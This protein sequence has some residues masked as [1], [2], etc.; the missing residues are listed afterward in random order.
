MK[1]G[2]EAS[3]SF[4]SCL[5]VPSHGFGG[6]RDI[7]LKTKESVTRITVAGPHLDDEWEP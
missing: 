6:E 2:S 4:R 7:L 3:S 5:E 1:R